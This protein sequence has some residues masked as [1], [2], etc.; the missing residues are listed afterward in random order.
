MN[1]KRVN[2]HRNAGGKLVFATGGKVFGVPYLEGG[3]LIKAG[4]EF[5]LNID[6][7]GAEIPTDVSGK[8]IK[9]PKKFIVTIGEF[10]GMTV[11]AAEKER[12]KRGQVLRPERA[13]PA[14]EVEEGRE[15]VAS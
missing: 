7:E 9:D 11:A 8:V 10:Q 14:R 15:K 12:A 5:G 1:E 6:K 3:E 13:P 2:I 4:K